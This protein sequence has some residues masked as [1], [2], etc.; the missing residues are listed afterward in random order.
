[1]FPAL[2]PERQLQTKEKKMAKIIITAEVEDAANW[3]KGFRTHGDLFREQTIRAVDFAATG[4]NEVALVFECDDLEKCLALMNSEAT[5]EAMKFD[6]VKR[7]T[8]KQ[9]VLDKKFQP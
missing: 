6:G 2:F 9:F 1:V 3:E 7:D 8:V 4:E 5:E